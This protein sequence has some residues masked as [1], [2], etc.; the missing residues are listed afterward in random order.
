MM[1]KAL[2]FVGII[3]VVIAFI[4]VTQAGHKGHNSRVTT[5]FDRAP[6]INVEPIKRTVQVAIP[7]RECWEEE[8][9]Y[10]NTGIDAADA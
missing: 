9:H 7:E 6:V 10:S 5:F 1:R 3:A 8:V 2:L 4:P